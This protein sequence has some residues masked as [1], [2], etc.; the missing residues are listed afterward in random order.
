M[1]RGSQIHIRD[2]NI[3]SAASS[4]EWNAEYKQA[5]ET[6]GVPLFRNFIILFLDDVYKY[7]FSGAIWRL[8]QLLIKPSKRMEYATVILICSYLSLSNK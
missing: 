3:P 8:K 5:I 1:K 6:E 2:V 4:G 7:P